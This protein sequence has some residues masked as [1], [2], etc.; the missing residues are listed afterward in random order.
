MAEQAMLEISIDAELKQQAEELYKNLGTSF[1]EAV[2]IFAR[3]SVAENAMPFYVHVPVIHK[4]KIPIGI[5]DGKFIIPDDFD[6]HN[7][8]IAVMFGV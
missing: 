4:N 8:E 7:D 3:Q 2:R 5:A 1:A 6:K